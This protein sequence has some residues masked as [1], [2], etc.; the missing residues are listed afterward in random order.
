MHEDVP[1]RIFSAAMISTPVGQEITFEYSTGYEL[2]VPWCPHKYSLL[3][4]TRMLHTRHF[5]YD[6]DRHTEHTVV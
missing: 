2:R 1:V 3:I 5:S 4:A 6:T